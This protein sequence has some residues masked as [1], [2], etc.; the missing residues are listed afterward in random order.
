MK[1][2]RSQAIHCY[3]IRIVK[4][5]YFLSVRKFDIQQL[6]STQPKFSHRNTGRLAEWFKAS[7]LGE[8]K[9]L[10]LKFSDIFGC[11]GSNPLSLISFFYFSAHNTQHKQPISFV[12]GNT[13]ARV[14]K[15]NAE[16]EDRGSRKD[17]KQDFEVPRKGRTARNTYDITA[18][19]GETLY[20]FPTGSMG[21]IAV[22]SSAFLFLLFNLCVH[23]FVCS[24]RGERVGS[25]GS[26]GSS[27]QLQGVRTPLHME[28]RE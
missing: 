9:H 15:C 17:T 4:V 6:H 5:D 10:K 18:L 2:L 22:V 24:E 13:I 25:S 26:S 11:K 20:L 19:P 1:F 14:R 16:R 27:G 7:D 28:G 21:I 8:L 3:F 12:P 23:G